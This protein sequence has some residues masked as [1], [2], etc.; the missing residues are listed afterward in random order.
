MRAMVSTVRLLCT[1][2]AV[3]PLAGACSHQVFS[4]PAR[5]INIGSAA[6]VKPGEAVVG[7]R[8]GAYGAVF[9]PGAAIA[10]GGARYG[11]RPNIE[12]DLDG[13]YGH[14]DTTESPAVDR[15]VFTGRAGAKLG[16][17]IASVTAGVG[18]GFAP[19]IGSFAAADVGFVLA[20]PNC[21]VVPFFSPSAFVSTPLAARTVTFDDAPPSRPLTSG[22]YGVAAGLEVVLDRARCR[23][24]R[25][26]AR[27]QLG[28]SFTD[29]AGRSESVDMSGVGGSVSTQHAAAGIA[30]GVELPL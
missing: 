5:V 2:A 22:G 25:T 3:L 23:Q 29:V 27:L 21:Y 4:P 15:N 20:A 14:V 19:A 28:V 1:L 9:E 18:V 26:P 16:N 11:V 10:S 24:Q 12:A 30:V 13:T 8:G 17:T 6:P 7:M